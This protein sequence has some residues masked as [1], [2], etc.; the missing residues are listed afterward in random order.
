M[1]NTL[2]NLSKYIQNLHFGETCVIVDA[3]WKIFSWSGK[4]LEFI[5]CDNVLGKKISELD[6]FIARYYREIG[7]ISN[8]AIADGQASQRMIIKGLD[9]KVIMVEFKT[10]PIYDDEKLIGLFSIIDTIKVSNHLQLLMSANKMAYFFNGTIASNINLPIINLTSRE[11]EV[12][13]LMVL[14]KTNKEIGA[15]L[16]KIYSTASPTSSTINSIIHNQLHKKFNTTNIST[17]I[18]KAKSGGYLDQIPP[19][20]FDG[21]T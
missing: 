19:I 3:D 10:S 17:L 11:Q 4:F 9:N 7:E 16:Q 1:N 8:L 2:D 18:E 14:G 12:L 21:P 5:Q 20:F 15:I 6:S 13:F